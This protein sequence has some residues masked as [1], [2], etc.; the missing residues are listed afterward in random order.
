MALFLLPERA[1]AL[2]VYLTVC[3]DI[4]CW[5]QAGQWPSACSHWCF[6]LTQKSTPVPL[7]P[8]TPR[9]T[10]SLQSFQMGALDSHQALYLE[11]SRGSIL[12]TELSAEAV[13]NSFFPLSYFLWPRLIASF[14]CMEISWL[15]R[16]SISRFVDFPPLLIIEDCSLKKWFFSSHPMC[17]I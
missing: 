1:Q 4:W 11:Q 17:W 8:M 13:F 6:A 16:M 12:P 14:I 7:V 10:S 9:K 3:E 15:Q 5:W 2:V